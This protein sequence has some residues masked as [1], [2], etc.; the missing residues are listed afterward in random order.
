MRVVADLRPRSVCFVGGQI[1]LLARGSSQTTTDLVCQVFDSNTNTTFV[2]PVLPR[3]R[4]L[5]HDRACLEAWFGSGCRTDGILEAITLV[6]P[7]L[8][9]LENADPLFVTRAYPNDLIRSLVRM[10]VRGRIPFDQTWI[11]RLAVSLTP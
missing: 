4:N 2:Q 6:R 11:P 3:D 10:V 1:A 7:A 9:L 8:D 5:D